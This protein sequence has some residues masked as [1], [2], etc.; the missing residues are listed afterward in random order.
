M[1]GWGYNMSE[2]KVVFTDEIVLDSMPDAL[3]RD[4][5]KN[6]S[7]KIKEEFV[8]PLQIR[9]VIV[10]SKNGT[11]IKA[12]RVWGP[13]GY[14]Y[15]YLGVYSIAEALTDIANSGREVL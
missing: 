3:L 7:I 2:E 1:E 11:L 14:E 8:G 5:Y 13:I 15:E 10:K 9:K 6:K 4:A 12:Y